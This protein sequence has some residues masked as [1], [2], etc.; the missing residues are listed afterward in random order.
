M[1]YWCCL[2]QTGSTL[3]AVPFVFS[4]GASPR[5][6]LT[7]DSKVDTSAHIPHDQCTNRLG[8]GERADGGWQPGTV[9]DARPE[10]RECAHICAIQS[11]A[12]S[13]RSLLRTSFV[14][15][16][17][18]PNPELAL[19]PS[20][21]VSSSGHIPLLQ[22]LP[23]LPTRSPGSIRMRRSARRTPKWLHTWIS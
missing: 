9:C 10:S 23:P 3:V 14:S 7:C 11:A 19:I 12:C 22:R 2:F 6:R 1:E 20:Q 8:R 13:G 5:L 4:S 17:T 18:A 21:S 16:S 15:P